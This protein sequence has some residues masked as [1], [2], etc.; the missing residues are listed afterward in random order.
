MHEYDLQTTHG[1]RSPG[2]SACRGASTPDLASSGSRGVVVALQ[3]SAG[4]AAVGSLLS[5]D[6]AGAGEAVRGVLAGAGRPLDS[7]VRSPMERLLG[8]DLSAVRVHD[9]AAAAASAHAVQA[10]AYTSGSHL[11]FGSGGYQPGTPAGQRLLA[12]ELTHVVQ[13]AQGPVDGTTTVGGL[14]VSDP[15]DRF[16]REAERMADHVS[17]A[18]TSLAQPTRRRSAATAKAGSG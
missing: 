9:D 1:G 4:N 12:H 18:G 15:C 14:K 5:Q 17:R 6:E 8:A 7:G 2:G 3:R 11:V 13:Q 10:M 16:E